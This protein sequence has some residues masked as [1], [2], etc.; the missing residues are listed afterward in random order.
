MLLFFR[1]QMFSFVGNEACIQGRVLGE[2]ALHFYVLSLH[3]IVLTP[4]IIQVHLMC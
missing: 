1:A 2:Y 3:K 4:L